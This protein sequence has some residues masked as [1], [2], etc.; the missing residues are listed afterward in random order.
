LVA[1]PIAVWQEHEGE[2]PLRLPQDRMRFSM[3]V[4]VSRCG[5]LRRST[6]S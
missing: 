2:I 4:K 6:L 1:R 3:L 5:D